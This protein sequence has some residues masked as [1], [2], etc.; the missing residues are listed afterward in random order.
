MLVE[1]YFG[2]KA[3]DGNGEGRRQ[4][5]LNDGKAE[6]AGQSVQH[7]CDLAKGAKYHVKLSHCLGELGSSQSHQSR[8][9]KD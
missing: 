3:F 4:R 8:T 2:G 9:A 6:G 7:K 5:T 1:R